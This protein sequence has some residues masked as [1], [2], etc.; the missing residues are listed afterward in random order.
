MGR[1]KGRGTYNPE[2]ALA[3]TRQMC[4]LIL[5]YCDA[6]SGCHQC[7]IKGIDIGH[8]D[9]CPIYIISMLND[10]LIKMGVEDTYNP[11]KD[12]VRKTQGHVDE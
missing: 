2:G 8:D 6:Q 5:N 11:Q 9:I 12:V 1:N 7:S 3:Y 4:E 10:A